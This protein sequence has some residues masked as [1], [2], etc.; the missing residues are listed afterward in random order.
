[1]IKL[2]RKNE[3]GIT[4][5][6][7]VITIIILLILAGISINALI[8]DNG[9]ISKG[10]SAKEKT[11]DSENKENLILNSY[12]NS[13]D[14]VVETSTRTNETKPEEIVIPKITGVV[15]Q[16]RGGA[17]YFRLNVD[18]YSTLKIGSR[19]Y[20]AICG[21]TYWCITGYKNA[22]AT[23][24]PDV[25]FKETYQSSQEEEFDIS[26]YKLINLDIICTA[27]NVGNKFVEYNYNNV[28]LLP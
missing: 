2:I 17:S 1:M 5:I 28:R 22:E 18:K 16:D 7:L 15:F 14:Q 27:L 20:Q 9:I 21:T 23:G 8:G 6:A 11:I 3:K 24:T 10:K 4:I 13:I 12:E 19:N 25:I 26:E